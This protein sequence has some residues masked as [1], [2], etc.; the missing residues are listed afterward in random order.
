MIKVSECHGL[1]ITAA[2]ELRKITKNKS[3]IRIVSAQMGFNLHTSQ[4][5]VRQL[6]VLVR[7]LIIV[8]Q[9]LL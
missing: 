9:V 2:K 4:I 7:S 6:V 1:C 5:Q 8:I 3:P